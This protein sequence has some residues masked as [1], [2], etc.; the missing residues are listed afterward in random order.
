MN[1]IVAIGLA[2]AF[3][4]AAYALFPDAMKKAAEALFAM[5]ERNVRLAGA[6]VFAAGALVVLATML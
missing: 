5:P 4:G 1:L 2:M 3:E 6:A